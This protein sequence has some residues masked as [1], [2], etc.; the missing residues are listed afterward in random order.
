MI[1]HNM[2]IRCS[3]MVQPGCMER[4]NGHSYV[5]PFGQSKRAEP[6]GTRRASLVELTTLTTRL[7]RD[8]QEVAS[9][10]GLRDSACP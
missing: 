8:V 10:Q 3:Q 7:P 2:F 1:M 9:R 5:T 4:M 6:Q